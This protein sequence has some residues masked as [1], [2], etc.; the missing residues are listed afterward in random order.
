MAFKYCTYLLLV[1]QNWRNFNIVHANIVKRRPGARNV[2]LQRGGAMMI[3][4]PQIDLL[5]LEYIG[6]CCAPGI[7]PLSRK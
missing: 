2:L 1:R 4:K 3:H 6:T 7:S 5:Y